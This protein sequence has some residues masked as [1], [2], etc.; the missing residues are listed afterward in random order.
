VW[1]WK[2]QGAFS[3]AIYG[4]AEKQNSFKQLHGDG[5]KRDIILQ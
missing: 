2:K 3:K 5:R 4:A 1:G